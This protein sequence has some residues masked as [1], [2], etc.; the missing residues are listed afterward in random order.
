MLIT[1]RVL[2]LSLSHFGF[3]SPRRLGG[4]VPSPFSSPSYL[5]SCRA[6]SLSF[7]FLPLLPPRWRVMGLKVCI[8]ITEK[9]IV[10]RSRVI[11]PG[12]SG[13]AATRALV[14]HRS[15][16]YGDVPLFSPRFRD[17]LTTSPS[18]GLSTD[19]QTS[20]ASVYCRGISVAD[21]IRIGRSYCESDIPSERIEIDSYVR[22]RVAI[23]SPFWRCVIS[24]WVPGDRV[25]Q[26]WRH[27][28]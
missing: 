9:R 23:P 7:T 10:V 6:R 16:C 12:W 18:S 21:F 28:L 8:P 19:P 27:S 11:A 20:A 2:L 1:S 26:D 15:F 25:S 24:D 17:S 13:L 3:F 4:D 22:G 14:Y 5:L